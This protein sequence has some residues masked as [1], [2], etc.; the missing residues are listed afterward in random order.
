M[1]LK[2]T[3]KK[4]TSN[5]AASG[6][7]G[8]SVIGL[9][10]GQNGIRMVQLSG[11]Q[12]NQIQLDK[13]AIV[14]LPQNIVAGNDIVDFDQLVSYLQECYRKLKTNCKQV[15]LALPAGSVT[16]E[17]N[18]RYAPDSS[19]MSLQELVEAEVSRIGHLDEM[20]YDWQ[21]VG[22][23]GREQSVLVVAARS[24]D[25]SKCSDLVEEIGLTAVNVDVDVFAIANAF[26]Y[27]DQREAG[28]FSHQR[29]A[30]F[31]VG[32]ATMKA[33]IMEDGKI[34]YRHESNF[35]MEQLIQLIQRNYQVGNVEAMAMISGEMQRPSD[36]KSAVSDNFNMQIAQEV[37][38]ALQFFFTTQSTEQGMDIKQ[39]FISGCGCVAGSGL[40]EAIYAQTSVVTQQIAPATFAKSKISD[41]QLARDAN[42][43]TTA[44]GLALR[45]L[46]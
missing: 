14:P 42:A 23:N 24:D 8:R 19:D 7:S 46:I 44:F 40:T 22:K 41:S 35:G 4:N 6:M 13:Y 11:R 21:V 17:E 15:N 34:L 43:L 31:D 29:V 32:D 39:I 26:A 1:R 16:I 36:Y 27:A 33:L 20:N 45:G 9:D 18:L 28:E 5:K 10:I 38:R 2:K 30:L 37:Q 25:V 12:I 3:E